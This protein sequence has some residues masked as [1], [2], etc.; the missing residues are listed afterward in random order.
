M[1]VVDGT[2]LRDECSAVLVRSSAPSRPCWALFYA[3][4]SVIEDDGEA[5]DVVFRVPRKWIDAPRDG[6]QFVAE[7]TVEG[8][9][10][11]LGGKDFYHLTQEGAFNATDDISPTFRRAGILKHGLTMPQE[12]FRDLRQKTVEWRKKYERR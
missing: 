7:L 8:R 1:A 11:M 6:V 5:V 12:D 10:R 4:G 9:Y 3:D 2:G